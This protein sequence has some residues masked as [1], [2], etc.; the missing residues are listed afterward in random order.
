[1]DWQAAEAL[2]ENVCATVFDKTPCTLRPRKSGISPN[3]KAGPDPDRQPFDFLGTIELEPP[4][5]RLPRHQSVDPGIRN[6]TVS[7]DAVLTAHAGA[8]PYRPKRGD[9][10]VSGTDAWEIAADGQDG[11]IRLVYFL[12]RARDVVG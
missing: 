2:T 10:V 3:H 6:G 7:Y 11:S 4:S 5:D 12:T 9:H 1:M 8:W